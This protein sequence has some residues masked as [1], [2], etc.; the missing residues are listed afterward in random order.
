[1]W[2]IVGWNQRPSAPKAPYTSHAQLRLLSHT[3]HPYAEVGLLKRSKSRWR[4]REMSL[5]AIVTQTLGR[6]FIK[7]FKNKQR[8]TPMQ[9]ITWQWWSLCA[10][11]H[12]A[13]GCRILPVWVGLCRFC[14]NCDQSSCSASVLLGRTVHCLLALKSLN[15]FFWFSLGWSVLPY[16]WSKL[17]FCF[18]AP[19]LEFRHK[20]ATQ[21]ADHCFI[22]LDGFF[23]Y[24]VIKFHS[25]CC[26]PARAAHF[27]A[28]QQTNTHPMAHL[29]G[30]GKKI[31]F[32]FT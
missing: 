4:C 20:A 18:S 9:D 24:I 12:G 27:E 19:V 8:K 13:C 7:W 1:M 30:L 26:K 23:W 21:G 31:G 10:G 29:A 5:R 17:L 16:L 14:P 11:A 25:Q 6:C 32:V 3:Y 22:A 2:Q 28:V 15:G